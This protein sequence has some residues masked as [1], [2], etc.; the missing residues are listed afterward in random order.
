MKFISSTDELPARALQ[1]VE[2]LV[3]SRMGN[4]FAELDSLYLHILTSAKYSSQV[5]GILRHCIF[6]RLDNSVRAICCTRP[7]ISTEDIPLFLSDV[8]ALV[9]L[10]PNHAAEMWVSLKHASLRDFFKDAERSH[11]I[12]LSREEYI[13]SCLPCYFQLLGTGPQALASS[14]FVFFGGDLTL[15]SE[16]SDAI[17]YSQ[18]AELL[19]SLVSAHS[20]QDIWNFCVEYWPHHLLAS[21]SRHARDIAIPSVSR[22]M[23]AIRDSVSNVHTE[24]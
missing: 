9:S 18:D 17:T 4:P 3:P 20:P 8:G 6:T 21:S 22:Y 1:V 11:V 24:G 14:L 19:W 12:Y 10:S 13:A 7:S 16:L 23:R 2:G 5:L 15:I